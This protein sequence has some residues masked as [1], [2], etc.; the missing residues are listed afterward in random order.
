M[1]SLIVLPSLVTA[2]RTSD[3][4]VV[5]SNSLGVPMQALRMLSRR[6]GLGGL[7]GVLV[8][9]SRTAVSTRSRVLQVPGAVLD[10]LVDC[11]CQSA[12]LDCPVRVPLRG[13]IYPSQRIPFTGC[14]LR[15][16]VAS[17]Q[18]PEAAESLA[19]DARRELAR[20]GRMIAA[21][22]WRSVWRRVFPPHI[23]LKKIYIIIFKKN[24]N[25][26]KRKYWVRPIVLKE[27]FNK[28]QV[29]ILSKKYWPRTQK[30]TRIWIILE[31]PLN[32]LRHC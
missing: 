21:A 14:G 30:N 11:S 2:S 7:S 15:D 24:E 23:I 20:T 26:K 28:E 4:S 13:L 31:W 6:V 1:F 32:Y 29:R 22:L 5:V 9:A 25:N 18:A 10:C 17:R 16:A 19:H 27:D 8:E 3:A 12:G